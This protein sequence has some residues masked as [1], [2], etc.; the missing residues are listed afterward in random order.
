MSK[1]AFAA[2]AALSALIASSAAMAADTAT[3]T[4]SVEIQKSCG[5]TATGGI[6]FTQSSGLSS[7]AP[8]APATGATATVTCTNGTEYSIAA[9]S[10]NSFKMKNT[11]AFPDFAGITYT[12][13]G[14]ATGGSTE[15]AMSTAGQVIPGIGNGSGQTFAFNGAITNWNKLTPVAGASTTFSDTVTLTITY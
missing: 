10:T 9:T 15:T 12:L 4:V 2:A 5:I 7:N 6:T 11:D 3:F 13:S 1:Y 8:A 14:K